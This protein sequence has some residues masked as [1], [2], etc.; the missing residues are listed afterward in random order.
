MS[1]VTQLSY[2]QAKK[3]RVQAEIPYHA[4]FP[5]VFSKTTV[6]SQSCSDH[7]LLF[8]VLKIGHRMPVLWPLNWPQHLAE[9]FITK[10]RSSWAEL[11]ILSPE[12]LSTSTRYL[13]NELQN[14]HIHLC[15]LK[16]GKYPCNACSS[17]QSN[18][19]LEPEGWISHVGL[20]K[21]SKMIFLNHKQ[22]KFGDDSEIW[23]NNFP[24]R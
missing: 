21:L 7:F 17:N 22:I 10:P 14:Q 24:K 20:I 23:Q 16:N 1:E 4:L 5:T 6:C 11:A 3:P 2:R 12:Q 13:H 19:T 8:I 18:Y 15:A 9:Y